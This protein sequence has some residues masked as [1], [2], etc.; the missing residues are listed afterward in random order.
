M[1]TPDYEWW[2]ERPWFLS[3]AVMLVRGA[4]PAGLSFAEFMRSEHA[5][6]DL[7]EATRAA[8]SVGVLTCRLAPRRLQRS[9]GGYRAWFE[10]LNSRFDPVPY[11]RWAR[12]H[13][14]APADALWECVCGS[15]PEATCRR[16]LV[17][18]RE[19]HD[20]TKAILAGRLASECSEAPPSSERADRDGDVVELQRDVFLGALQ[21]IASKPTEFLR[22]S[23]LNRA[24]LQRAIDARGRPASMDLG[25]PSSR[26]F[27]R[28]ETLRDLL[29][30]ALKPSQNQPG[31]PN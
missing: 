25:L 17:R 24:A 14:F 8:V 10:A 29:G 11:V 1:D 13:R 3:E 19:E 4:D 21:A 31:E 15:S 18:L 20:A 6:S 23:G 5:A 30:R 16:E 28:G 12:A 26:A 9:V 2:A 27:P 7:F 22:G